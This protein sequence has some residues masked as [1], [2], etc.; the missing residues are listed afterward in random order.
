MGR[1]PADV[2]GMRRQREVTTPPPIASPLSLVRFVGSV[3]FIRLG[4][5]WWLGPNCLTPIIAEREHSLDMLGG[6]AR[7]RNI[8]SRQPLLVRLR[9]LRNAG[10]R[11][12]AS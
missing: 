2:L 9:E 1:S 3:I 4:G 7:E 12:H 11:D 10:R 8:R 5:I 6:Q